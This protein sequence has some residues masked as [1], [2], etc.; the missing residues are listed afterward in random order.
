MV[1]RD[2]A[3]RRDL[4]RR[5]THERG[6]HHVPSDRRIG[7]QNLAQLMPGRLMPIGPRVIADFRLANSAPIEA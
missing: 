5:T 7:V 1:A 4:R 6:R 2:E 3:K